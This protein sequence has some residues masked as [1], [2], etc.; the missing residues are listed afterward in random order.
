[1]IV[2]IDG[3]FSGSGG[4]G[5]VYVQLRSPY[6]VTDTR[7]QTN[8]TQV[9]ASS[10]EAFNLAAA[11]SPVPAGATAVAA[12]FTVVPGGAPGYATI[13]PTSDRTAPTA[14]NLDW[15]P[16]ET[17]SSFAIADTSGNGA[18]VDLFASHGAAIN[19]VIDEF[20]YFAAEP[21]QGSLDRAGP[22]QLYRSTSTHRTS[23]TRAA[24]VARTH[25]WCAGIVSPARS[26]CYAEPGGSRPERSMSS[27]RSSSVAPS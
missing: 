11:G 7:V 26:R 21:A 9:A 25:P 27:P 23:R 4:T 2:D 18:M 24:A 3:Y 19:I 20:G 14:S 16:G 8:G 15:M 22:A 17:V 6:R 13:Y 12:N 1:V 10:S 5:S